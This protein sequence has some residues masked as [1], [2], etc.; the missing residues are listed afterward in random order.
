MDV[1]SSKFSLQNIALK[2]FPA[3]HS[4]NLLNGACQGLLC[5]DMKLHFHPILDK[6]DPPEGSCKEL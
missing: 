2:N 5:Q 1:E 6:K 3:L 4:Y